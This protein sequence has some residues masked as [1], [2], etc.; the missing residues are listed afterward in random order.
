MQLHV[1]QRRRVHHRGGQRR[2]VRERV[3]LEL[4]GGFVHRE[5]RLRDRR[6]ASSVGSER[7]KARAHLPMGM[8][9]SGSS[10]M[11]DSGP[12]RY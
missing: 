3:Q 1:R 2:R 9:L 8:R 5:L 7:K 6:L 12:N 4:R 10:A 11:V